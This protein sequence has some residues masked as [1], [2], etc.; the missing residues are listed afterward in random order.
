M[1]NGRYEL[2]LRY[3]RK[4][5]FYKAASKQKPKNVGGNFFKLLVSAV[6]IHG[7]ICVS[8][9]Y[10][11]AWLE[12][13]QVVESV[14]STIITEIIAPIIVYGFTKTVENIFQKNEL[15][16]SKPI[17]HGRKTENENKTSTEAEESE[18]LG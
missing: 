18:A 11:L 12:H 10:V 9:S 14:S 1:G 17:N 7:M 6:V 2:R 13:T 5:E 4:C 15:S 16:F 3:C 8:M